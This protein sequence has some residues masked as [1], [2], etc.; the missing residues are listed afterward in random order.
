MYIN[1]SLLR[2]PLADGMMMINTTMMLFS[3]SNKAAA[4][5]DHAEA[6]VRKATPMTK[7]DA[8]RI[9]SSQA[10][11]GHD[12]GKGSFAARAQSAADK[13]KAKSKR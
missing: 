9:Q 8:A 1:N 5:S 10:K 13:A 11:A 7:E 4:R 2:L 3:R 6:A 12:T